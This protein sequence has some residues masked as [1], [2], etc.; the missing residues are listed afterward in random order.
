MHATAVTATTAAAAVVAETPQLRILSRWVLDG[1]TRLRV[2]GSTREASCPSI[3][4]P[5]LHQAGIN[6]PAEA[7]P[8][9]CSPRQQYP[10]T[11][12]ATPNAHSAPPVRAQSCD[13]AR[14]AASTRQR[15][16]HCNRT[17]RVRQGN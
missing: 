12:L 13:S 11:L 9:Q 15:C 3:E 14:A 17:T 8:P 2:M 1:A 4:L 16:K 7:G 5:I 6:G 10:L